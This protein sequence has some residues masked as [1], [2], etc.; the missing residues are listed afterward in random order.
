MLLLSPPAAARFMQRRT[1]HQ[2]E[3]NVSERC[4]VSRD[5]L[6]AT[7]AVMVFASRPQPYCRADFVFMTPELPNSPV[8]L[9]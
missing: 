9:F 8:V 4:T 1:M 5:T 3:I 7:H 2:L 6:A